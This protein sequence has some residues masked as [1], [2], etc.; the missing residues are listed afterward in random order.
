MGYRFLAIRTAEE[1][2]GSLYPVLGEADDRRHL[3]AVEP[4][5]GTAV[6]Q[7]PVKAI[8]VR[9][10]IDG[11][12]VTTRSP[13][14]SG[15]PTKRSRSPRIER[16]RRRSSSS[17]R[18]RTT[19]SCRPRPPTPRRRRL[20]HRPRQHR[21]N[22]RRHRHRDLSR[23]RRRGPAGRG[24]LRRLRHPARRARIARGTVDRRSLVGA[25]WPARARTPILA[26]CTSG[27]KST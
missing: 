5:D 14:R 27:P 13:P 2:D 8:Y 11:K 1:D 10:S 18:C 9:E 24:V 26:T 7:A 4:L 19:G 15:R 22:H 6:D 25:V 3:I 21:P 20:T 16:P 12:L 23:V 17:T